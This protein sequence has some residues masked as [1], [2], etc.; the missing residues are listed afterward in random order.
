MTATRKPCNTLLSARRSSPSGGLIRVWREAAAHYRAG[1]RATRA[2]M[3]L[4][5]ADIGLLLVGIQWN[6]DGR[7]CQD[8]NANRVRSRLTTSMKPA[9]GQ[10]VQARRV[11][12]TKSDA[13]RQHITGWEDGRKRNGAHVGRPRLKGLEV[14]P[15]AALAF[16]AAVGR[17]AGFGWAFAAVFLAACAFS[18]AANSALTFWAMASVSTL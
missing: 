15:Y 6:S 11:G 7:R 8:E 12:Q 9:N 17:A 16:L 14:E 13:K 4:I 1:G 2:P 10:G 18:F 3:D 5:T